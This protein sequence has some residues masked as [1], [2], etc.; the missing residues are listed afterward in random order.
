MNEHSGIVT[1]DDLDTLTQRHHDASTTVAADRNGARP[2]R[3]APHIIGLT[4][5][6]AGGAVTLHT[7]HGIGVAFAV[8]FGIVFVA[9][10][11][12]AIVG[13]LW[14]GY[15]AAAASATL[16]Q[17]E[18]D[19]GDLHT[20]LRGE[21]TG[22]LTAHQHTQLNHILEHMCR[23]RNETV[24]ASI[25]HN[26][27]ATFNVL[28]QRAINRI[29]LYDADSLPRHVAELDNVPLDTLLTISAHWPLSC[30]HPAITQMLNTPVDPTWPEATYSNTYILGDQRRAFHQQM[31]DTVA[32]G[33]RAAADTYG[34]DILATAR[35]LAADN[36][37]GNADW[38]T[39]LHVAQALTPRPGI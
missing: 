14:D 36:P 23:Q 2:E 28:H 21:R 13:A 12:R 8:A 33:L 18:G 25:H 6:V 29:G 1:A 39:L 7:G 16:N 19:V 20:H 5:S 30:H 17:I 37:A 24:R 22:P 3:A 31:Y 11:V 9:T 34:D 32:A 26:T 35:E 10:C 38:D 27:A 15:R 4:L